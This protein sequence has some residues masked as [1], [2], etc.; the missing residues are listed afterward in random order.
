MKEAA[1]LHDQ[2]GWEG[3]E[4]TLPIDFVVV[5]VCSIDIEDGRTGP[6]L[7]TEA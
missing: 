3:G 5:V 4:S 7:S 2:T 1:R 6:T